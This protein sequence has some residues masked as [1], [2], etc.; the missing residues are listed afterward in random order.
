MR[1]FC[2]RPAIA[3][4]GSFL[5][6]ECSTVDAKFDSPFNNFGKN[7][8]TYT[9]RKA[10]RYCYKTTFGDWD[11]TMDDFLK[12]EDDKHFHVAPPHP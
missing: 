12:A 5:E 7:C 1:L 10:T 6:D 3:I 8:N 2:L 9:N 11:C 4:R